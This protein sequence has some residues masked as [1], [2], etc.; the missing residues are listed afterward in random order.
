MEITFY[1]LCRE[2]HTAQK[3]TVGRI[4]SNNKGVS[5]NPKYQLLNIW[6]QLWTS[7]MW[8]WSKCQHYAQGNIRET[9]LSCTFPYYDV[10]AIGRLHRK[11]P[12]RNCWESIGVSQG[13]FHTRGLCSLRYRRR[14]RDSAH[15]RMAVLEKPQ[16]QDWCRNGEESASALWEKTMKFRFQNKKE[17]FVIHENSERE[18]LLGGLGN[19]RSHQL[20]M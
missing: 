19:P 17:L 13:H 12:R 10:C 8:P 14:S 9:E 2:T 15:S 7:S 1:Q 4:G 18:G 6:L 5:Q 16:G 3:R 20:S 11:I